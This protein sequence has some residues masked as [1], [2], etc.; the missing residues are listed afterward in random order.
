MDGH[1]EVYLDALRIRKEY[2]H[3]NSSDDETNQ[4]YVIGRKRNSTDPLCRGEMLWLNVTVCMFPSLVPL[5]NDKHHLQMR[6]AWVN[7]STSQHQGGAMN[8][9][10][11]SV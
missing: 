6:R 7:R 10:T 5:E 3:Q 4:S 8:I 1:V 9:N 2:S 11:A